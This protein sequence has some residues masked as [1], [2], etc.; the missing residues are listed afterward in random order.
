MNRTLSIAALLLVA[1]TAH[2]QDAA[3][4]F[5]SIL[6]Q[7]EAKGFQITSAEREGAQIEVEAITAAGEAVE[8]RIDAATGAILEET[9]DT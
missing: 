7:V 1:S 9:P 2:A 5:A 8:L 3:P 4:S 6:V